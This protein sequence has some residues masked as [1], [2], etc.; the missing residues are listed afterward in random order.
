MSKQ[1]LN[2]SIN[3]GFRVTG[4][5][6]EMIYER[7]KQ[8]NISTLRE[9]LLKM[10]VDGRVT[11]ID[12]TEINQCTRLLRNVSNNINQIAK[13]A[14]ETGNVYFAEIDE[15]LSQQDQIWMQ[16]EKIIRGLANLMK[17]I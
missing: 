7:M 11:K 12:L 16:Q 5:E 3:M 8:A 6:Q 4:D 15:I 10:A 14:N 1:K 13:K 9:Y 17:E 2:R